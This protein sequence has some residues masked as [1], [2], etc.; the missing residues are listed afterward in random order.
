MKAVAVACLLL[1]VAGCGGRRATHDL[2][3]VPGA[4]HALPGNQLLSQTSEN[5]VT[6]TTDLGFSVAVE[7]TGDSQETQVK[8]TLTIEQPPSP[9]VQT[10]RIGAIQ[11]GRRRTVIFSNLGQ[12]QFATRTTVKVD[13]APVQE[14]KNLSDNSASFP[15]VFSLG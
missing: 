3:L 13:L 4:V 14:E 7:N 10:K 6:A 15:V 1:L 12:V 8:V 2:R 11:S 5:T 9:I